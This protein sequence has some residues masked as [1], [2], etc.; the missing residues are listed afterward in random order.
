VS[1]ALALTLVDEA[2][3]AHSS[4]KFVSTSRDCVTRCK[5]LIQMGN[6]CVDILPPSLL[7]TEND[8]PRHATLNTFIHIP[9]IHVLCG[10]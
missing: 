6:D 1:T 7:A 3:K 9:G 2:V 8:Y 4:L 10:M 5:N